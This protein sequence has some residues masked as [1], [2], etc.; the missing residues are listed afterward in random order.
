MKT[1]FLLAGDYN[2]I[3]VDWRGGNGL[4]YSQATANTRLV[5]AEI[6]VLINK[7]E[8]PHLAVPLARNLSS[9]LLDLF[10]IHERGQGTPSLLIPLE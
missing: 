8:V 4:P 2:V 7:L 1:A 5:G 10:V 9:A 3:I 6:A